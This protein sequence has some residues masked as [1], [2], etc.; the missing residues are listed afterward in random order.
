MDTNY[1]GQSEKIMPLKGSS[2]SLFDNQQQ[3][4]EQQQQ[5]ILTA[6]NNNQQ[7]QHSIHNL[8]PLTRY[9]VRVV[10]V[11]SIG[12]SKPSVALSLRTEEEG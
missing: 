8:E 7:I 2:N 9:S 1:F 11:N 10:A 3:L 5:L 6:N 4:L 12:K